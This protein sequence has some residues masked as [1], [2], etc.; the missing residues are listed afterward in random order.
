MPRVF[1]AEHRRRLAVL[2]SGALTLGSVATPP[3]RPAVDGDN[4]EVRAA[5]MGSETRREMEAN[6]PEL[7]QTARV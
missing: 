1:C 5:R 3:F 4:V 6:A 7:H 2:P